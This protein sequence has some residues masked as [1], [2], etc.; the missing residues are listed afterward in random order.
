MNCIRVLHICGSI[1][2]S[3]GVGSFLMNYYRNIDR[4]KIQ[5]D[6]LSHQETE[7]QLVNEIKEMGGQVYMITPKSVSFIKNIQ[8]SIKI[9]NK[10]SEH[11]IIHIH[12]ASTT[13]FVYLLIA[14]L[15]GKKVRII[16]SHATALEKPKGSF[17]YKIHNLLRP[18][19][20]F[21]ATD[22]FACSKAAGI[23][24]Y[25][26]RNIDK[27]KIINN[28]IDVQ[29]F[30]YSNTRANEI[31]RSMNLDGKLVIGNIG[32]FE[33]PKNHHFLI[34]IFN[35][36]IQ[37]NH[38]AILLLIGNGKLIDEIKQKVNELNLGNYVQFL[39]IRRDI[40]DLLLAMDIFILT[41]RFEG[42]P[43]VL[44][45]AQASG[46][47]I[48]ASDTITDEVEITNLITRLPIIETSQYWAK[49]IVEKSKYILRKDS[50]KEL[51]DYGYDIKT[52]AKTL[53]KIYLTKFN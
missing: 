35:E 29:K 47:P 23:W 45:E 3:G 27:V 11:D 2:T 36:I 53:E 34:D 52:N 14:K 15:A 9:I 43:V 42:F 12:T 30:I 49:I 8:E 18:L 7:K 39:G 38:N 40:P 1:T 24:L 16:H 5:F 32:R 26:R 17:Q 25:G 20:L 46:L 51:V 48:F 33:Y 6:F 44:L 41:S 28:A 21:L 37:I 13:S 50:Y 22:L 10:K 31:K 19:I 4:E